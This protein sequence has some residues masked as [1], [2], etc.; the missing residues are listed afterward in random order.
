MARRVARVRAN[1][2]YRRVKLAAARKLPTL[3]GDTN[4]AGEMRLQ[5][6]DKKV[7]GPRPRVKPVRVRAINLVVSHL[8]GKVT[9]A[10]IKNV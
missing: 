8:R 2:P 5:W 7:H 3:D 4:A 9:R 10:V 1:L 6:R